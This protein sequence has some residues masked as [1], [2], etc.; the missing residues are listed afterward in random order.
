MA[1]ETRADATRYARPR[2]KAAQAHVRHR[3]RTGR[4]HVAGGHTVHANAREGATW[5]GGR[6]V[7][8]PRVS[9]H[10]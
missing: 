3:W 2:G 10:W 8:G 1:R 9:G 6:Q 7:K 5:Q 4:G